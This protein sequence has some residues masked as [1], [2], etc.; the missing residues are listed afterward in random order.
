VRRIACQQDVRKV[1]S[2]LFSLIPSRIRGGKMQGHTSISRLLIGFCI[3]LLVAVLTNV[4]FAQEQQLLRVTVIQ[5]NPGM[6]FEFEDFLKNEL[7]PA[8]RKGG[9]TQWGSWVITFGNMDRYLFTTPLTNLAELDQPN[10]LLKAVGEEGLRA[11]MAKM[12]KYVGSASNSLVLMRPDLG[13]DVPSSYVPKMGVMVNAA[14]TP[15]RQEDYEKITKSIMEIVKKTN[16]KGAYASRSFMGGN[17]NEY[18]TF[19]LFDS[20]TDMDRFG[21]AFSKGM[22]EANIPTNAGIV[23]QMEYNI[24]RYAPELSQ[25]PPA[26]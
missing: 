3:L 4:G 16:A 14:V 6:Q 5:V 18:H 13:V 23:T 17:P 12:Q 15:G 26:E 8:M 21:Q 24:Y 11:M 25:S 7:F 9:A 2:S 1:R 22:D 19:I 10:T 20:F